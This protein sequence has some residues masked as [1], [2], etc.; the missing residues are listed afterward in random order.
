ML[1]DGFEKGDQLGS[2]VQSKEWGEENS[3]HEGNGD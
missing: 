3:R 1:E 2:S